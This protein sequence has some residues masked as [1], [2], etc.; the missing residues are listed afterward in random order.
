MLNR[1]EAVIRCYDPCLS[2]STHALGE[3]PLHVQLLGPDGARARRAACG[4]A[5]GVLVVGYGNP[6]RGD[7]GV[8]WRVAE[9]LAADQRLDGAAVLQRHQLTPEL[10]LDISAVSL[11]VFIDASRDLPPGSVDVGRVERTDVAGRRR[12]TISA[13]PF[14]SRSLTSCTAGRRPRT[15]SAAGWRRSSW[16]TGC[17]RWSR[18]RWRR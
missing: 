16:E 5:D 2:C 4:D 17:P 7:D 18:L 10:A 13:H 9:R 6:L 8:G 11:V 14:S 15:S 3:M 12:R 1:V